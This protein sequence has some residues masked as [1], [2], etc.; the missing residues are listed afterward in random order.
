MVIAVIDLLHV[1]TLISVHLQGDYTNISLK[2]AAM[3]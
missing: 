3:K 2:L 1:S